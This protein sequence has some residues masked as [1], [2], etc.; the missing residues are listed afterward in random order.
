MKPLLLALFLAMAALP[1]AALRPAE[2]LADPALETRARALGRE[3]RCLVCQNQSIDDSDAELAADLRRLV[4]ERLVAGDSDDAV[5][6]F[7]VARYGD[8]VLLDPP[9]KAST[10]V[11]WLGPPLLLG[12]GILGIALALRRRAT[13]AAAALNAEEQARLE[14]VLAADDPQ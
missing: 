9:V 7:L 11:L 10:L 8:F 3:L 6:G 2:I 1:A 5:R 14:R 13:P 4:R 12:V